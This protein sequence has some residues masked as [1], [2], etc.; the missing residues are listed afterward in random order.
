MNIAV[1]GT[2]FSG[3]AVGWFLLKKSPR[4]RLTFFDTRGIGGGASG[5]AAGLL[6]PFVGASAK[7]NREGWEG[8]QATFKLLDLASEKVG[9]NVILGRGFLRLATTDRQKNDYYLAS[10]KYSEVK[11]IDD[12]GDKI[13]GL[14][15]FPGIFNQ[16]GL[17]VDC[18][19]YLKG[20]WKACEEKGAQL[21]KSKV[22]SLDS[23]RDFDQVI[24]AAGASTNQF[25][26][27][28]ILPIT[29]VK[30]QVIELSWPENL[31][32]LPFA[33]NSHAY[34]LMERK[35]KTCFAGATYERHF[36]SEEVDV[37]VAC[38]EIIPKAT[39]LIP[40]L[41][42]STIINC[43]AGIRASTPDHMPIIK[44]LSDN[45][46]TI[47]GMGSRG[48]LY[49]ALYAERLADKILQS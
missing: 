6:H 5:V 1:I 11:W 19:L 27:S 32:P 30:G 22:T 49:H 16:E 48:L 41:Q 45:C 23:L 42:K 9:K 10:E 46:W 15:V 36:A 4:S 40:L 43:K 18:P 12:I 37:G 47:T 34:L 31:D 44:K 13:P 21:E 39:V 35:N 26:S 14:N 33:L 29:P 17:S 28:P 3:L 8:Y 24:L 25:L 2:G 38:R 7:L 20:L